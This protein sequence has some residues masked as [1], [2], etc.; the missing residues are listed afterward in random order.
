MT[1]SPLLPI[2][3][4]HSFW[5]RVW[6]RGDCWEWCGGNYVIGYGGFFDGMETMKAHRVSYELSKGPIPDET[7]DIHHLCG[8]RWCVRPSHLFLL[9]HL[10]HSQHHNVPQRQCKQGHIIAAQNLWVDRD[11]RRRCRAC[12]LR[13]S[14]IRKIRY[15]A[16][17][18]EQHCRSQVDSERC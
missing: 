11:G 13:R 15:R 16:R 7:S 1:H 12:T 14:R 6:P 10:A 18:K 9:S 5:L 2:P 17:L 4:A 8:H 3:F